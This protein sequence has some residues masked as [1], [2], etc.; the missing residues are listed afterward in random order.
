MYLCT[1]SVVKEVLSSNFI[2]N[3]ISSSS[4]DKITAIVINTC[5][6]CMTVM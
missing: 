3:S 6:Y 5:D 2:D 4:V 1:R